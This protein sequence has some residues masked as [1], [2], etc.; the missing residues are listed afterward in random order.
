MERILHLIQPKFTRKSKDSKVQLSRSRAGT[1]GIFL[2]LL[3]I[4]AFMLLPIAYAV[5]QAFKPIEE[6]FAFPPRFFV[7]NPTLSNFKQ[8][9]FLAGNLWVP[10]SR[11]L[12]NSLFVSVCGTLLYL[13]IASLAAFPLAKGNV[14]GGNLITGLIILT[15]LFRPEVTAIPSYM[16]ISSLKMV[17]TYWA[18]IMPAMASSIGVF[19]MKQFMLVAI[20]DSTLE[21]ARIDGAGEWT[22]FFRIALPSVK[23]ALATLLIFTFQGLWNNNGAQQYIYSEDLKQLPSVLSSI[24]AAGIFRAGVGSAVSVLLMLPPILIFIFSQRSIMETMTHSG[25]K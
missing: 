6:I 4:C 15:L 12:F 8:V 13:I 18:M 22:A 21:A 20:P 5:I 19:L 11:Y 2:F 1:I 16:V 10:F 9:F 23:P 25:L 14:R 24:S 3:L 17:D 7:R